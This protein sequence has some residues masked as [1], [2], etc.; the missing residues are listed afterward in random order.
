VLGTAY[1]RMNRFAEAAAELEAAIQPGAMEPE[2]YYHLARAYGGLG[3][4]EKRTASLAKFAALSRQVKADTER[5]RVSPSGR[6]NRR[7]GMTA[8]AG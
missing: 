5:C 3:Q 8:E 4:A 1:S 6:E 2:V 7:C